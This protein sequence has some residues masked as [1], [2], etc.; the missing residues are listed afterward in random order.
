MRKELIEILGPQ[1]E[2]ESKRQYLTLSRSYMFKVYD[3][4]YV[5]RSKSAIN[6]I[7]TSSAPS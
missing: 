5:I 2:A 6:H 3:K 1:K 4:K 7:L